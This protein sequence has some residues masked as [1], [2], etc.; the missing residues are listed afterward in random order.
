MKQI[1]L[2]LILF[3]IPTVLIAQK[4]IQG[5]VVDDSNMPLP[6]A[7]VIEKGTTN[8]T[9]TDFDGNFSIDVIDENAT[10][11]ISFMGFL[12]QEI[13]V[14]K[15][16]SFS[17]TL[18]EDAASLDEVI[19]IGYGT[20]KKKLSTGSSLNIKGDDISKQATTGTMEALQGI[21]PGVSI[22]RSSAQP[23]SATK[24]YIRGIGTMGDASPLYIVDGVV[25]SDIDYLS[26]SDIGSIDVLKDAASAAIYGSR[27]AN[28]VILVTTKKGKRSEEGTMNINLDMYSG[29]QNVY[30]QPDMLN[31]QEFMEIQNEGRAND[32]LAPFDFEQIVGAD[33]WAKL[34][35]GWK[36]TNWF[37]EMKIKN[38]VIQ[39]YALN[40][41]G[42]SKN[43]VYSFGA[44]YHTNEGVFGKQTNSDYKR[45]SLRLNSEHT[46][47]K[48]KNDLDVVKFGENLTYSNTD[49]PTVALGNIYNNNVHSA[50]I[51]NPLLPV[52]DDN[53]DYHYAL[54][55][56]Y[57]KQSNPIALMEYL[58]KNTTNIRDKI[59][60][61]FYLDIQPIKNLVFRSSYGFQS[62]YGNYRS[63]SPAYDLGEFEQTPYDKVT[64]SMNKGFEYTFTNTLSYDF[65]F[66]KKHNFKVLAGTEMNRVS[67][68]FR[69]SGTNQN[70]LYN[71]SE[72][73]YLD[74]YP[75]TD[76]ALTMVSGSDRFGQSILSYFGRVSYNYDEKYLLTLVARADGSSNFAKG[77]RW[78]YFPSVSAGWVVSNEQFM[79]DSGLINFLKVRTSFGQNGNQ[80]I[81]SFQ[82]SSTIGTDYSDYFFGPDKTKVFTGAYPVRVPNPNVSWET[83]QQTDLGFDMYLLDSRLKLNFD[84]YQKDT[85]DWLVVAP[86]VSTAGA[87]PSVINGGK[88]RNSGVELALGWSENSNEFKYSVTG[89]F[90][91]NKNEI[92]EIANGEGIIHGS[93]NVLFHGVTEMY[94][95]Q[96]GYPVGYFWGLKT[97]GIIQ[98]Q[99]EADEYNTIIQIDPRK[100]TPT[101]GDLRYVDIDHN[102]IIDDKD[103]TMLGDPNPK[104]NFGIQLSMEYKG[105]YMNMTGTG[106]G[107][108][109]IAKS[110]RSWNF[111][112]ENYTRE[113]FDRWHGEGTSNSF[114][115]LS[116]IGNQNMLPMSDFFVKDATYFRISNLT[117]GY[118]L[119]KIKNT[120]FKSI[121][122]FATAK[123]LATFTNYKGMNPEVG[124]G[125]D[126]WASGIDLGMYPQSRS[127]LVGINLNL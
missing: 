115:K 52:Y 120:P 20:V 13:T 2:I 32:G 89:S 48:G 62:S 105:F 122:V 84:W 99:A 74:N 21:S 64:Q 36:G 106:Q 22:T 63:W 113:I 33:I 3:L 23:G 14:G 77:N 61:N 69:V 38:G 80:N 58:T 6:G 108:M 44:S 7:T 100:S 34:Q 16:K 55:T 18:V 79:E 4:A 53:G 9:Q 81:G 107:G 127:F 98:N 93:P 28:G 97:D 76:P 39:N 96:V 90:A 102:N 68:N 54:N 82:Y 95:A 60:G 94:R 65:N 24:V 42:G 111:D 25:V 59:V 19:V 5:K 66:K 125:A 17:I 49:M 57:E 104:Y 46:L 35:N 78:G 43:S 27:A 11:V 114:P 26:P 75:V 15:Q 91:Y 10:L 116:S 29:F 37:D 67:H 92:K 88:I 101:A 86:I 112:T 123:N 126:S 71:D 85:K 73:A 12:T 103:K 40:I 45:I 41:S 51:T 50:I 124:Y 31:A 70:G 121:K 118:N 87:A 56:P 117:L 8:G 110:Y 119:K 83:S 72:Y 1:K 47:F 30:N 109:Q